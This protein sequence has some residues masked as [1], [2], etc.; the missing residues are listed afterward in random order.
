MQTIIFVCTFVRCIAICQS[1]ELT[2][3]LSSKCFISCCRL[4]S[5]N[6]TSW[7]SLTL[8][9][10]AS[11]GQLH[12]KPWRMRFLCRRNIHCQVISIE[13]QAKRFTLHKEPWKTHCSSL[14]VWLQT[15]WTAMPVEQ[16]EVPQYPVL[17]QKPDLQNCF[18]LQTQAVPPSIENTITHLKESSTIQKKVGFFTVY[19]LQLELYSRNKQISYLWM[20]VIFSFLLKAL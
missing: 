13:K 14:H 5:F 19:I 15:F 4:S 16:A 18:L 11:E 10:V 9:P 12:I 8:P 1:F 20:P 2:P 7:S 17:F 6:S 3:A